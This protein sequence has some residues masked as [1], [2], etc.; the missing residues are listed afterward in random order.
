[1]TRRDV[2]LLVAGAT[3]GGITAAVRGA[4]EGLDTVLVGT[5]GQ[6]GGMMASGL[7]YTDTLTTKARSPLVEE[8]FAGV[9]AHYRDR[10]GPESPQY[11]HCEAG[12]VFEPNVATAQFDAML[13]EDSLTLER[14]YHPESVERDGRTVSSVHFESKRGPES[15]TVGAETVVDATYEGDVAACAGVPYRVGRESRH[16]WGEQFAG[17][18]VT[19]GGPDEYFPH[20]AVGTA[21]PAVPAGRRGPLDVPDEKRSGPLDL[22]PHPFCATEI[23]AGSTG[24]GDDAI[25]A[26]NYRVTLCCDPENRRLP[27]KPA[28]YDRDGYTDLLASLSDAASVRGALTLRLLPN[29]KA[30]MNAADLPGRN[31][32]YP[33]ASVDRR[34]EIAREHQRH[35]LGLLYF[36]QNDDAVPDAAQAEAR[37]WGLPLDEF[38]DNDNFPWQL[39]VRE[40]RRIVG[41][42]TFTEA[43]GRIGPHG[44]RTPIHHDAIAIAEYPMDSHACTIQTETDPNSTATEN[45]EGFFY[46]SSVTRPSQVPYRTLLPKDV[47]NLLCP[48]ALSA[49]HVGFG[50]I[51]LEPTWMHIGEAAGMASAIGVQ[52][53]RSPADVDVEDLQRALLE[54]GHMLS[55]FN[56]FDMDT[57]APWVEAVQY[58]GTKGFFDSYDADP[59]A[60]LSPQT[61]DRWID[62]TM[63]LLTGASSLSTGTKRPRDDSGTTRVAAF[64]DRLGTALEHYDVSVEAPTAGRILDQTDDAT[65]TRGDA[66]RVLYELL[67]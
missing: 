52:T 6:V 60:A 11:D 16:E 59:T 65:I 21:D 66:C 36:L 45:E 9:R 25:Q 7:S 42:Y 38:T 34:R 56:E 63:S 1:V 62:G 53:D 19:R 22:V 33:E 46:A 5:H 3:P 61:A 57:D 24:A 8:F 51:R 44:Q 49:T 31:H 64:D 13:E 27:S 37:R 30:D 67:G 17:R 29:D 55:F 58:F 35:A 28:G 4:R 39:Y 43:D 32:E 47:D 14:A 41:R 10:Y 50:T 23:A 48:V 26:Y 18:I 12:Y 40:A 54:R 2:D 20:E 15:L